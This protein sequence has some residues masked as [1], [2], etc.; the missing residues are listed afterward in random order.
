MKQTKRPLKHPPLRDRIKRKAMKLTLTSPEWLWKGG[1]L[2]SLY[3]N[4]LS[5][6]IAQVMELFRIA[7]L[8]GPH[9]L[10]L[11]RWTDLLG[12]YLVFCWENEPQRLRDILQFLYQQKN[13]FVKD[14]ILDDAISKVIFKATADPGKCDA[15][16]DCFCQCYTEK[17]I[18]CET[19]LRVWKKSAG[20][21]L[22]VDLADHRLAVE[23][24]E[25]CI[26][27]Q[28]IPIHI[29][30]GYQMLYH[31]GGMTT[32]H[33]RKYCAYLYELKLEECPQKYWSG[34]FEAAWMLDLHKD[35]LYPEYYTQRRRFLCEIAKELYDHRSDDSLNSVKPRK[36]K[37]VVILVNG[38]Y[39]KNHASARLEAG[40]ANELDHIG[41]HVTLY[42]SDTN[43]IRNNFECFPLT[44]SVRSGQW[45]SSIYA[46][47]HRSILQPSVKIVYNEKEDFKE[48]YNETIRYICSEDPDFIIDIS[49]EQAIFAPV[50]RR[51]YP[52]VM[53]PLAGIS[54]S[55]IF[56]AYIVRNAGQLKKE[57]AVYHSVENRIVMEGN[58][59]MPYPIFNSNNFVA[60]K[61]RR[62]S[63]GF[64]TTDTIV[65]SAGK[66]LDTELPLELAD[67]MAAYLEKHREVKWILVGTPNLYFPC[68]EVAL[69][70]K[71]VIFWPYEKE[72]A[73]LYSM[74]DIYLDP[75]RIGGG[76]GTALAIQSGLAVVLSDVPSDIKHILGAE[77]CIPGGVPE[78]IKELDRLRSDPVYRKNKNTEMLWS[79]LRP[80][81]SAARFC[82]T[83]LKAVAKVKS[84]RL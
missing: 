12:E 28:T 63:Y 57:N 74:C 49:W 13:F 61:F 52:V 8:L 56:D 48:R 78:V 46:E 22:R 19:F 5:G 71:Q 37:S 75:P 18:I 25:K 60:P 47:D 27:K 62:S 72:L 29:I 1:R 76:G 77:Y 20:Q 59:Y 36:E 24:L 43:V 23:T 79:L 16:L 55:A 82:N 40:V 3:W 83:I 41:Y 58:I 68:L 11:S 69:R 67:E 31:I 7:S 35:M 32:E 14:I 26:E 21:A 38:I 15:L 9:V 42:A 64:L 50:L 30:T 51:R 2:N 84:N 33:F 10:A 70:R 39:T 6:N 53:V 45:R 65:V 17:D 66:R 73:K 34:V 54:T 81:L 4:L 80:E 44:I